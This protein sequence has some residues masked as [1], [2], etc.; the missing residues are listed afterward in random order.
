M[1]G[2]I[3]TVEM[4]NIFNIG[5]VVHRDVLTVTLSMEITSGNAEIV[6]FYS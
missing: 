6:H 2:V 1:P 4:H 3:W 5:L